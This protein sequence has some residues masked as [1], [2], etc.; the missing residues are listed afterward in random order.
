M[1]FNRV[2][3]RSKVETV[4]RRKVRELKNSLVSL[5]D[6]IGSLQVTL[7]IFQYGM[8]DPFRPFSGYFH[9]LPAPVATG[10]CIYRL[11]FA[12]TPRQ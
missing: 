12:T 8:H 10:T 2:S 11:I 5:I 9:S 4:N 3:S 7:L 1:Y 6:T